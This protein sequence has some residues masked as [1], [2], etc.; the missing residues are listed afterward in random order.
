MPPEPTAQAAPSITLS[1]DK[2]HRR[3]YYS[4]TSIEHR[5]LE[6][7]PP[8][9]CERFHQWLNGIERG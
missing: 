7:S 9:Q 6:W 2:R 5:L 4:V 8:I 3:A 1:G